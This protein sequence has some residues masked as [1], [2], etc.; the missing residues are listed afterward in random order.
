MVGTVEQVVLILAGRG[1]AFG[2]GR[3]DKDMSGRAGAA[4]A[5]QGQQFIKTIVADDLHHGKAALRLYRLLFTRTVDH[6]QFRH[7][8]R[9]LKFFPAAHVGQTAGNQGLDDD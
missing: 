3:V 2:E 1:Q 6:N 9:F 4:A 5:A 7:V 8:P